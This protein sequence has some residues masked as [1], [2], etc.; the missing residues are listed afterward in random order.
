MGSNHCFEE[1]EFQRKLIDIIFT[2]YVYYKLY[3]GSV[4]NSLAR[5]TIIIGK[6]LYLFIFSI[7]KKIKNEPITGRHV[8]VKPANST[9]TKLKDFLFRDISLRF[10]CFCKSLPLKDWTKNPNNIALKLLCKG[11]NHLKKNFK[12]K[13]SWNDVVLE[14]WMLTQIILTVD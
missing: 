2:A 4:V 8:S 10:W 13:K 5:K 1:F 6:C 11:L 12:N 14:I 7:K 9:R 3:F